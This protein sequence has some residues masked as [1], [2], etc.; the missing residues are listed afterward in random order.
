V[1]ERVHNVGGNARTIPSGLA[2]AYHLKEQDHEFKVF[3]R[4][5]NVG[6]NA[7]TIPLNV[8]GVNR[9]V[10]LGVNDFNKNSY[11][12]LMEVFTRL[13]VEY[14]PLEDST[15][16]SNIGPG[17][18]FDPETVVG[19]TMP[20]SDRPQM[21]HN[22]PEGVLKGAAMFGDAI[23]RYLKLEDMDQH[24]D[25]QWWT[26]DQFVKWAGFPDDYVYLNLYPRINGMY[27]AGMIRPSEMPARQVAHYYYLQ[28]GYGTV[29]PPERQY[30]VGGTVN[31]IRKLS[32][33]LQHGLPQVIFRGVKAQIE[34]LDSGKVRVY[35]LPVDAAAGSKPQ[36]EDFDKVIVAVQTRTLEEI[37]Y[38]QEQVPAMVKQLK[39]A[40]SMETD[41][42]VAHTST[43]NMPPDPN[44]WATYN[45]NVF[46]DRDSPERYNI[47]YWANRHQNDPKNPTYRGMTPQFFL[48]L[49]PL[50]PVPDI[51]RLNNKTFG[52]CTM[53]KFYHYRLNVEATKAQDNIAP[54]MMKGIDNVYFTGGYT[55]GA[56]LHEECWISGTHVAKHV[57]DDAHE[58]PHIYL[59]DDVADKLK[60]ARRHPTPRYLLDLM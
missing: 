16:Y 39:N 1:F 22:A 32:A 2:A 33:Y 43:A 30:W 47:T 23:K 41:E 29:L 49:N 57:L 12:N 56:G 59:T 60:V 27:F 40:M 45:I 3:E 35:T 21:G 11:T 18:A 31:W 5:H 34:L 48:T 38:R 52:D 50:N 25:M 10:D 44:L 51:C 4:V 7:R 53:F 37:Y 6:G 8:G 28:E 14:A 13:G 46:A 55:Q 9:W 36:T 24:K 19:Y 54:V 20:S 58:N 42:V 26:M 15:G 17:G